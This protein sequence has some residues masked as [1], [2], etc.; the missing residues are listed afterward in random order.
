MGM[1][2]IYVRKNAHSP[3]AQADLMAMRVAFDSMRKLPCADPRS[4]YFQG[5]IHF[6]PP[7][8]EEN[9]FCPEYLTLADTLHGWYQCTHR[10]PMDIVDVYHFTVWHRFYVWHLEKIVRQLSGKT[11]FALPYWNYIDSTTRYLPEAYRIPA[12]QEENALYEASRVPGLNEGGTISYESFPNMAINLPAMLNNLSFSQTSYR[13]FNMAMNMF[14]HNLIHGFIGGTVS[15]KTRAENPMFN[16][17]FNGE[18][19]NKAGVMA[20]FESAGFDPVFWIHH[21]MVDRLWEE[22]M[23]SGNGAQ[24]D[25]GLLKENPQPYIFFDE[26]GNEVSYTMEEVLE[27]AFKLDYR[28]D[29]IDSNVDSLPMATREYPTKTKLGEDTTGI[30]VG[31]GRTDFSITL[32]NDTSD[33][34]VADYKIILET[35]VATEPDQPYLLYLNLPEGVPNSSADMDYTIW[36][37]VFLGNVYFLGAGAHAHHHGSDD[38]DMSGDLV[39]R[40]VLDISTVMKGQICISTTD[41][42]NCTVNKAL[43]VDWMESLIVDGK[44]NFSI[45]GVDDTPEVTL[46]KVAL[47]QGTYDE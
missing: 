37:N 17:I 2:K 30:V 32:D 35:S 14:P 15:D 47:I 29:D 8:L 38:M 20:S 45:M 12:N 16:P 33:F 23:Y 46:T 18:A 36:R 11:D 26:L 27:L 10:L 21:G 1:E 41:N 42:P 31:E 34:W 6:V 5:A 43:V 40:F 9:P 24:M 25:L 7:S 28:Y 4:W 3:E 19:P 44:L 39:N 22:W 13:S